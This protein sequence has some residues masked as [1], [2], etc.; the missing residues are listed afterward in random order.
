VHIDDDQTLRYAEA[1]G[2]RNVIHLDRQEARRSGLGG[3]IVH[4]MCT[5]AMAAA[6]AVNGLAGGDPTL[7][8]R[9][10]A[11]FA[12]P[13]FPGQDLV[14]RFWPKLEDANAQVF[15][16]ATFNQDGAAV[17]TNAETRVRI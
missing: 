5:M 11:T 6:G 14:T 7:I 17:L 4:G 15:G 12:R 3:I 9:I 16:F 1:S 2:D 10:Q 8:Q 13:V